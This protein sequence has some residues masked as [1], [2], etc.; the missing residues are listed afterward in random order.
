MPALCP[1]CAGTKRQ[2]A[3]MLVLLRLWC[4]VRRSNRRRRA[5]CGWLRLSWMAT[6]RRRLLA[7]ARLWRQRRDV[8]FW[9]RRD[10]RRRE[11]A[12]RRMLTAVRDRQ[13]MLRGHRVRC[14]SSRRRAAA[15]MLQGVLRRRLRVRRWAAAASGIRRLQRQKRFNSFF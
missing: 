9:V 2:R 14:W 13:R 1:T 6:L 8:L 3:A 7:H 11:A 5:V 10:G 15:G 4:A 12:A